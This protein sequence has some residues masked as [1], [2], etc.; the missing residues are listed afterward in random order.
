[1]ACR[2]ILKNKMVNRLS[3]V[4]HMIATVAFPYFE[5]RIAQK[6]L[7]LIPPHKTKTLKAVEL[8]QKKAMDLVK[9]GLITAPSLP[10]PEVYTV[11]S[12]VSKPPDQHKR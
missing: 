11:R 5:L 3:V 4:L 9:A 6:G 12:S 1:M 8:R 7:G 10:N 2:C